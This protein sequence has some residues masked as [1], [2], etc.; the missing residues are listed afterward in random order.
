MLKK[1]K[2]KLFQLENSIKFV[3]KYIYVA[4]E[5]ESQ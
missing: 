1:K 4:N 5:T 2:K 3:S